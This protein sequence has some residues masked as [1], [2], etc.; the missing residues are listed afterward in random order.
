VIIFPS[1]SVFCVNQR[2]TVKNARVQYLQ[3]EKEFVLSKQVSDF[4]VC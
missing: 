1:W 3:G 2:E 4:S